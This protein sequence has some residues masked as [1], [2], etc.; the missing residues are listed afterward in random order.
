MGLET[1]RILGLFGG[2]AAFL[3][4]ASFPLGLE[5]PVARGLGLALW[6]A[7][8]WIS[9]A[10]PVHATALVPALALPVFGLLAMKATIESYFHPLIFLFLGGF[11]IARAMRVSGLDRRT[12]AATLA[13]AGTRPAAVLAAF[14]GVTAA[15]SA[16]ISNTA[17]AAMMLPIGL[18]VL[19]RAGLP[20]GSRFGKALL[21]GLAWAASIGGT[22]TL[23]GTPPNVALAGFASKILGR[24]LT[25]ASWL[26][27]GLPFAIVM[28]PA[29][30]GILLVRYRPEVRSI[31]AAAGSTMNED[32]ERATPG[33]R[34]VTGIVFVVAAVLW[35]THGF[36]NHAPWE[37]VRAAG[38][39]LTDPRIAMICGSAL[40]VLPAGSGRYATVLT[41]E[42]VRRLPWRVLV[43]FGGGLALGNGLF[44]S[45]T[46]GWVAGQLESAGH[47]P[48][49]VLIGGVVLLAM[50]I[51][52]V[53]SNTATANMLV[54]LLFALAVSIGVDPYLLA[55][56][57]VLACSSAFMLPVATPP[58]AIVFGSGHVRM[59]DMA[60]TGLILNATAMVLIVLLQLIVTGPLL[61]LS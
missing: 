24:E 38:K 7:I 29:A 10:V 42:D 40:F 44:E 3:F 12:A 58:N 51:T 45:G 21:L 26:A 43:L 49:L 28:L 23:I 8:W 32:G 33:R 48:V 35:I 11:I 6:C 2:L 1:K 22:A 50:L 17:T 31:T 57:A 25:F 41:L 37:P 36:W 47:L 39:W 55:M 9:E 34:V 53:T 56:P 16:F 61:G 54:P 52:E 60:G 15:L 13:V 14:M 18:A 30:W 5:P 27:V 4:I 46:A 19:T 20:P 59:A